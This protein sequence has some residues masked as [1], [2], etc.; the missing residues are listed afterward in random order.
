ML[1]IR[2][3][4]FKTFSASEVNI[5]NAL[6]A[7]ALRPFP[8]RSNPNPLTVARPPENLVH[9]ELDNDAAAPTDVNPAPAIF[10]ASPANPTSVESK[11]PAIPI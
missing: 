11:D 3:N 5:G 10:A 9:F 8:K 2:W 4:A 7:T 6:V 1:L